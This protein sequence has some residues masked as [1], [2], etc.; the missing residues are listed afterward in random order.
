MPNWVTNRIKFTKKEAF[1][2][3]KN[4][5]VRKNADGSDESFDFNLLI[6]MPES[7][8]IEAGSMTDNGIAIVLHDMVKDNVPGAKGTVAVVEAA[9]VKEHPFL[10]FKRHTENE[11]AEMKKD[12]AK[13]G[14]L[15]KAI[16][17]GKQAVQNV[18]G[19][20]NSTWY[21]WCVEHWGTKW[22][23]CRYR[24]DP[25][26]LEVWFETAWSCPV[27]IFEKLVERMGRASIEDIEWADEDIGN[28]CGRFLIIRNT[29]IPTFHE[30]QSNTAME[31]AI[32]LNAAYD[33][34]TFKNGEWVY[35]DED[36]PQA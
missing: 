1:E 33:Y 36:N 16:D 21:Q 15:E 10:G 6:K 23:A 35:K 13:R 3:F 2:R 7:L 25:E 20:G 12:Y 17:L 29:A 11:I 19:Y 18:L 32:R 24:D 4:E 34:Y 30:P 28:N 8:D 5:F 26:T 9:L 14:E 31:C 22:N 27:P